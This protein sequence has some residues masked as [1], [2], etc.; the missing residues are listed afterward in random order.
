[1]VAG[2]RSMMRFLRRFRIS[3]TSMA[4]A[5]FHPIVRE[6]FTSVRRRA[7]RGAAARLGLDRRRPAH[8]DC[9]ADR[10]GQDAGGVSHRH[11]RAARGEPHGR[12]AGRGPDRL[13]VA[14]QG[15]QHGHPQEPRRTARR[16]PAPGRSGRACGAADHGRRA[17][18]RHDGGGAGGDAADAA[19]HPGHHSGIALPAADVGP[20]PADAAHG[21]HGDRGR[22]PRGHRLAPR[23]APGAD[24]RAA[25]R[26]RRAAT[27]AHRPVGDADADRGGGAV[28]HGRRRRRLH[29]R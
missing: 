22:D 15:A 5:G 1:M 7:D 12:V 25:G 10:L 21:A 23:R 24:A 11:Q 20:Q 14:A 2:L 27:P 17:D 9:R 29:H 16:H 8:A 4:F 28:P 13:R 6:W 3:S 18:R 19:P 26:R